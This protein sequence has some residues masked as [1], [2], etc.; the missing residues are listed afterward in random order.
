LGI[1]INN[2]YGS[3]PNDRRKRILFSNINDN[4]EVYSNRAAHHQRSQ[5]AVEKIKTEEPAKNKWSI[6]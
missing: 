5:E 3:D 2:Y 4:I 1:K 6:F